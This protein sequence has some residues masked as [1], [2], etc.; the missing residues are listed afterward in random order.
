MIAAALDLAVRNVER[1]V[2]NNVAE[3][4]GP[5]VFQRLHDDPATLHLFDGFDIIPRDVVR[6]VVRFAKPSYKSTSVD[7]RVPLYFPD[8]F[9]IYRDD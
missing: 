5:G 6:R 3:V 8:Q 4:T 1:R 2:S 7:W 9:S